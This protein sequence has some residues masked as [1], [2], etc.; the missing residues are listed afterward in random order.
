MTR[1]AGFTIMDLSV[2]VHDDPKFRRIARSH[3]TLY[4]SAFTAYLA[5]VAASWRAGERVTLADAWP[6]LLAP[7]DAVEVALHEVGLLDS[8]GRVTAR[9]WA[10]WFSPAFER[11]EKARENG[12]RGGRAAHGL[13]P[14][15]GDPEGSGGR[16]TLERRLGDARPVPLR[17]DPTRPGRSDP[18]DGRTSEEVESDVV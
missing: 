16:A 17:S 5:V 8:R 12:S 14:R 2:N 10:S 1:G 18:G 11:R 6:P 3:P 4:A 15:S 7:D 9:A 13:P